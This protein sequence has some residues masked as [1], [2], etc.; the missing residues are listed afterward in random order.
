MLKFLQSLLARGSYAEAGTL[1][2]LFD[3]LRRF[4]SA[5][6]EL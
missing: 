1:A 5:K 2:K 6:R 4:Y 3:D